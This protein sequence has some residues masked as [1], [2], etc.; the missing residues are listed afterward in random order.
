MVSYWDNFNQ[1]KRE[2]VTQSHINYDLCFLKNNVDIS[3]SCHN[4][5]GPACVV[6]DVLYDSFGGEG[7][8]DRFFRKFLWY[9]L[10]ISSSLF[11]SG[12]GWVCDA[13]LSLSYSPMLAFEGCNNNRFAACK[14]RCSYRFNE[15]ISRFVC[16]TY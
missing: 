8:Y 11:M 4:K 13:I 6:V 10:R 9:R 7:W 5:D 2:K 15:A 3:S 14:T 16:C 12:G 1:Y